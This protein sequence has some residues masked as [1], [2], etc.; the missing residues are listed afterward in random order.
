MKT[1]LISFLAAIM[2]AGAL[3]PSVVE[4]QAPIVPTG[5]YNN[6]TQ[7]YSG[8]LDPSRLTMRQS[9]TMSY[10]TLGKRG[11]FSNLYSNRINYRLTDRLDL[12]LNLSFRYTPSQLNRSWTGQGRSLQ[13]QMFIPSFGLKYRPADGVT[14]ELQYNQLDPL[15]YNR[16]WGY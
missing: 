14:I 1:I 7:F 3:V 5:S 13:E 11:L 2:L 12:D 4:A 6:L 9:V 8:L 10:M 16:P 15:N